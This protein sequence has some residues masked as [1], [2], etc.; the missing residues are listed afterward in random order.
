MTSKIVE[1]CS[2]AT[3]GNFLIFFQN[4]SRANN[5]P[6][7]RTFIGIGH[8]IGVLST[9]VYRLNA[10]APHLVNATF[11]NWFDAALPVSAAK[12]APSKLVGR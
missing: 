1:L 8:S 11:S 9:G 2:N 12:S 10:L 4:V 3:A 5:W 6:I 7:A